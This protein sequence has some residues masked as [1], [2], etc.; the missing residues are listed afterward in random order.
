LVL[1]AGG[2]QYYKRN[3]AS[4]ELYDPA[5]G[6]FIHTGG[7]KTSRVN[8][9]ATLLSDGSVLITGGDRDPKSSDALA[10]AELYVRPPVMAVSS[11]SLAGPLA[12]ESLASLFGSGLALT[13]AR[14]DP[15]PLTG[16]DDAPLLAPTSLGG[17]SVRV[18]DSAGV[19]RLAPLYYVS[20]SRIDFEVPAGTASGDSILDV[21]N[22]PTQIPPVT[23]QTRPVSPGLL[24]LDDGRPAG[25]ALRIEQGWTILSVR[26]P[27]VLDDRPVYLILYA[28]GIRNRSSRTNVQITIGGTNLPVEYAGPSGAVPGLDQVNVRLTPDLKGLGVANLVLTADGI[29]SNIVS[30]DIR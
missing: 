11:A 12:P 8:H 27:I 28:T 2:A 17:V 10:S 24:T 23:A 18:R 22:S 1:V 7:M 30:V 21:L 3:L 16:E 15:L 20:P 26:D 5:A 25:Y 19:A 13:T 14:S 9:T 29:P 6:A 4:A